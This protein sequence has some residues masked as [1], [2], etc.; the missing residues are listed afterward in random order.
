MYGE[1]LYNAGYS[2]I[3]ELKVEITTLKEV[4]KTDTNNLLR[5][6]EEANEEIKAVKSENE[7]LRTEEARR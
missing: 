1:I 7:Q 5:T 6:L 3:A 4:Y 2:N